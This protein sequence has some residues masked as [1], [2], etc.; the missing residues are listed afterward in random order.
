MIHPFFCSSPFP[1]RP[2]YDLL[3]NQPSSKPPLSPHLHIFQCET[4]REDMT[5]TVIQREFSRDAIGLEFVVEDCVL[6][7]RAYWVLFD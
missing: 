1:S 7:G 6:V 5:F 2:L 3:F 4:F